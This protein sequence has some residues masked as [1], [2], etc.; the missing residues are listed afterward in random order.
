[1]HQVK[2]R[3]RTVQTSQNNSASHIV[4]YDDT[5]PVCTAEI[6]HYK[7]L[8]TYHPIEWLGISEHAYLVEEFGYT[9][10]QLLR[11]LH[12]LRADGVVV[13]GAAAF[14]TIWRSLKYYRFLGCAIYKLNLIPLLNLL[15][16]PFAKRSYT[17]RLACINENCGAN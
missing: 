12:V 11:H 7:K 3:I 8:K 2:H 10:E 15:Y 17:K 13:K 9:R 14:T 5:C 16:E 4:F 6:N 1:M